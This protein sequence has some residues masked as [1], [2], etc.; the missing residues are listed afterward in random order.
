MK[1]GHGLD[2]LGSGNLARLPWLQREF[3]MIFP[4]LVFLTAVALVGQI[5]VVET[6]V[7]PYQA[8][9]KQLSADS[10]RVSPADNAGRDREIPLPELRKVK[11]AD[12][13]NQVG[14]IVLTVRDGSSIHAEGLTS[15]GANTQIKLTAGLSLSVPTNALSDVR[16]RELTEAQSE[17]WEAMRLS[18]ME[19]DM[20]ALVRSPDSHNEDLK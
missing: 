10:L 20:L 9:F 8:Q 11:F 19:G 13:Q 1:S 14:A 16:L 18:R 12:I 4:N 5:E 2:G 3:R 15:D 6:A 7:P 17:Q